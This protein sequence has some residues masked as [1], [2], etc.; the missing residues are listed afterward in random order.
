M[1]DEASSAAASAAAPDATS[2]D[3]TS[4]I[5]GNLDRHLVFPLLEFLQARG[6]YPEEDIMKSKIDLLKYTN[7]V[8][9]PWTFTG[10]STARRTCPRT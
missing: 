3:I 8:D 4:K 2:W 5:A 9:L 6:I 1:V 7:M 10:R